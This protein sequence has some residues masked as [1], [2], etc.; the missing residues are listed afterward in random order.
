MPISRSEKPEKDQRKRM[1]A[2]YDGRTAESLF[3][4]ENPGVDLFDHVAARIIITITGIPV[5]IKIRHM[6]I[7]K[8][9]QDLI[10]IIGHYIIKLPE[11]ITDLILSLIHKLDD[12]LIYTKL[13]IKKQIT[14]VHQ[15]ILTRK[16]PPLKVAG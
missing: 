6:I 3:S 16:P 1:S 2:V 15:K 9:L 7:L 8:Y 4:A 10:L 12:L 11:L 5:K 13:P 14:S